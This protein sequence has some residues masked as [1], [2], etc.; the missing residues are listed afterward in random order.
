MPRWT[1][2]TDMLAQ[3]TQLGE[4]KAAGILTEAEFQAQKARIL[5]G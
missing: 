3:L 1:L 4:L 2:N 5:N